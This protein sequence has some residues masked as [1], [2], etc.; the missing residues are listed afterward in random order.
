MTKVSNLYFLWQ[1]RGTALNRLGNFAASQLGRF[2][3]GQRS[4]FATFSMKSLSNQTTAVLV[5]VL[6]AVSFS[7][8][9]I[10]AFLATSE[11]EPTANPTPTQTSEALTQ[12]TKTGTTAVSP[13]TPVTQITVQIGAY[14]QVYATAQTTL[15][16]FL[17]EAS[18]PLGLN[19]EVMVNG[20][21]VPRVDL[22]DT[23]LPEQ[24]TIQ[25]NRPTVTP[26]PTATETAV[27]YTLIVDGTNQTIHSPHTN[28]LDVVAQAGI[29]LNELDYLRP[30]ADT[31]L[32]PGA[33]IEVIRVTEQIITEDEELPYETV[34]QPNDQMDI[35]TREQVSIG[36]PGLARKQ[37]T[38][39]YENGV[40]VSREQTA[41]WIEREPVNEVTAYGTRITLH[42]IDTDQGPRE[43]WRVVKM[44]VTSYTAASSGKA[45]DDP[46]Y[47]ITASG[48]PAGKG[49]VAIDPNVVP[50]QSEV[51]VPGYG[52]AVAG[53]TGGGIRG[54]WIDL[55]WDADNYESWTGHVDVY[56]LAPVPPVDKINFLIPSVVP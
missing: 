29:P 23:V 18:I 19:D 43:Y 26:K 51:Y 22:Y 20:N 32:Q 35:D 4:H 47:G 8:L 53:D 54:R 24:V 11:G 12:A 27:S 44:R 5:I 36:T 45:P 50:F 49:V 21:P 1:Q 14:Q 37:V 25:Q 42:P 10:A 3:T 48:L 30:N 31:P 55:G 40:E 52:V 13:T 38:I 39:R 34:W 15:G 33:Q 17:A 9:G 16:G 2:A 46:A 7:S 56:Y 41:S 28:P 6:L